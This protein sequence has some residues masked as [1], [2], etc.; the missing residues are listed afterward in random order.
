VAGAV[1]AA[2]VLFVQKRLEPY[3][4]VLLNALAGV[5]CGALIGASVRS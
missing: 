4:R 5:V 3:D 2:G 1:P